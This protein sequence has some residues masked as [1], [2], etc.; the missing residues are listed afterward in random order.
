M[1]ISP[2]DTI[3]IDARRRALLG[4]AATNHAITRARDTERQA[5]ETPRARVWTSRLH[6]LHGGLMR[7]ALRKEHTGLA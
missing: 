1:L 3:V 4:E 2:A 7:I 5:V 6:R